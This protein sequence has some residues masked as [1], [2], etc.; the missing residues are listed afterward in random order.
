MKIIILFGGIPFFKPKQKLDW[1][2]TMNVIMSFR[3]EGDGAILDWR[4]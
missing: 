4:I 2:Y 3:E 1:R